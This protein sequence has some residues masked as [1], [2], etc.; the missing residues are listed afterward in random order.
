MFVAFSKTLIHAVGPQLC[1]CAKTLANTVELEFRDANPR[2][3]HG[4]RCKPSQ[5]PW[6]ENQQK[7]LFGNSRKYLQF[8]RYLNSMLAKT[9]QILWY[10]NLR[11]CRCKN[12]A[13][14][15]GAPMQATPE[16]PASKTPHKYRGAQIPPR[17]TTSRTQR[18][19]FHIPFLPGG[20]GWARPDRRHHCLS[21]G[22]GLG[23]CWEPPRSP[24]LPKRHHR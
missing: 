4:T 3:Y 23:S 21:M 9:L 15:I 14:K 20:G 1:A 24:S 13:N 19:Y 8:P 7:Y 22:Q 12:L 2:K 5:I 11:A 18:H 10:P 16:C 6:S 17:A